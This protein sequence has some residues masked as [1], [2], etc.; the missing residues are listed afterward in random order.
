MCFEIYNLSIS[1]SKRSFF[2]LVSSTSCDISVLLSAAHSV[3]HTGASL[4]LAE[5]LRR[6]ALGRGGSTATSSA[7]VPAVLGT[8]LLSDVVAVAVG[9]VGWTLSSCLLGLVQ[10]TVICKHST[11]LGMCEY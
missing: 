7:P 4:F 1:F 10:F 2:L 5:L 3:N 8:W 11:I 6:L 9:G